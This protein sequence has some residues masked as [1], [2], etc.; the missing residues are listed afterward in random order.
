MPQVQPTEVSAFAHNATSLNV[1]WQPIN[2]TRD[3]IRGKL[4]GYRVSSIS[5][6][7]SEEGSFVIA[8]YCLALIWN[9]YCVLTKKLPFYLLTN[10]TQ[11]KYWR[12]DDNETDHIIKLQIGTEQHGLIVGLVPNTFYWIRVMAYNSAGAGPESERFL[13]LYH[14]NFSGFVQ[15]VICNGQH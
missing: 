3:N 6:E 8:L 14:L 10:F 7:L 2:P 13:G 12:R 5:C 1:T 11:I 15:V 4:I 9:W